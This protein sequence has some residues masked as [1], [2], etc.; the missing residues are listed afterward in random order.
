MQN[1]PNNVG[2][3]L[4]SWRLG[5]RRLG[6]GSVRLLRALGRG[7]SVVIVLTG[8]VSEQ[9]SE[10]KMPP[11]VELWKTRQR[12]SAKNEKIEKILVTHRAHLLELH[13]HAPLP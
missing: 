13:T 10:N 4:G 7:V 8:A 9:S 6:R 2:G 11:P 3:F 5:C 12:R 1:V